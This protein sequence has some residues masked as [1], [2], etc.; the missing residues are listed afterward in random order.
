MFKVAPALRRLQPLSARAMRPTHSVLRSLH[1]TP[2]FRNV[3]PVRS[4]LLPE[5][6]LKDKVIVVSGGARGL[7]LVQAE[8]LLEAGATGEFTH[9]L[10]QP[11]SDLLTPASQSTL[12]IGSPILE[13]TP[14]QASHKFLSEHVMSLIRH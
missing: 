13:M 5:F 4:H 8:A 6:S 3:D 12:S 1:S 11:E 10:R 14:T 7:G 2:A 9:K